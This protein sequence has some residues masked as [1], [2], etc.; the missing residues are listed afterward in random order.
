MSFICNFCK[1]PQIAKTPAHKIVTAYREFH[2]PMRPK[3]MK[4]KVIKNGKKK[5]EF[6]NDP[7]GTGVQVEKE[8]L[9]CPSCAATW[10]KQVKD[11]NINLVIP[12]KVAPPKEI[13]PEPR[14]RRN[15]RQNSY[16]S[17]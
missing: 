10:E 16:N 11:H 17:Y 15:F 6:V 4:I 1:K 14:Q 8:V 2:H 13:S 3:A 7:G 12:A 9:S 5:T